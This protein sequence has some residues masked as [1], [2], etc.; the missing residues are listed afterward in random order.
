MLLGCHFFFLSSSVLSA[1]YLSFLSPPSP[2][3]SISL[4]INYPKLN[5]TEAC[6]QGLLM[7]QQ[8][9]SSAPVVSRVYVPHLCPPHSSPLAGSRRFS[10]LC[11]SCDSVEGISAAAAV[12]G[13]VTL[14]AITHLALGKRW[15]LSF[16]PAM[17]PSN[18][19]NP[20]R[21][22]CAHSRPQ[23]FFFIFVVFRHQNG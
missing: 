19:T 3:P 2:A 17:H 4:T 9:R 13:S 21:C 18:S 11:C 23:C 5:N 10:R 12:N 1:F 8:L 20:L 6:Q 22:C 16:F 14:G 7:R 15:S